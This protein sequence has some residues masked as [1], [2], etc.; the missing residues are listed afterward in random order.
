VLVATKFIEY[1]KKFISELF[2]GSYIFGARFVPI[3]TFID[4]SFEPGHSTKSVFPPIGWLFVLSTGN[5]YI[6][7]F[8]LISV[9]GDVPS[10]STDCVTNHNHASHD[11]FSPYFHPNTKTAHITITAVRIQ[12]NLFIILFEKLKKPLFKPIII[13]NN[14]FAT[15]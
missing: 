14:F 13:R 11:I 15:F 9:W 4:S 7:V 3:S 1:Q 8:H 6:F 5:L 10:F 12:R 2:E